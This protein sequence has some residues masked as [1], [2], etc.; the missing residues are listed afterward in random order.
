MES[1][2]KIIVDNAE[3]WEFLLNNKETD[4]FDDISESS[5]D[6]SLEDKSFELI[7]KTCHEILDDLLQD[8]VKNKSKI[9]KNLDENLKKISFG[10]NRDLIIEQF[11]KK[12]DKALQ[13]LNM[14]GNN[15]ED[16]SNIINL[17]L[18]KKEKTVSIDKNVP[19]GFKDKIFRRNRIPNNTIELV[20]KE[21]QTDPH[22]LK[23]LVI[24]IRKI[25]YKQSKA[26]ERELLVKRFLGIHGFSIV[27]R[28]SPRSLQIKQ[29]N[30][31]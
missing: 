16:I 21:F 5:E 18:G 19:N 3:D 11:Q 10:S 6:N 7:K 30:N 14:T 29:N 4:I 25:R 23:S 1:D 15:E 24:E 8:L 31:A 13:E 26:T 2:S 17:I 9:F 20:K 12:F 28:C 22:E 27:L